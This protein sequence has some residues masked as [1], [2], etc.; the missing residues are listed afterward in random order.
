MGVYNST[1]NAGVPPD[2]KVRACP[3]GRVMEQIFQLI[4]QTC[5][6][7]KSRKGEYDRAASYAVKA[8]R[9]TLEGERDRLSTVSFRIKT[10]ESLKEKIIRRK[11]YR[12]AST[13]QGVLSLLSDALGVMIECRFVSDEAYLFGRLKESFSE[14]AGGGYFSCPAFPEL[15]LKL[16]EPQPQRQ[17]NGMDI[18]RVDGRVRLPE[19]DVGFELQ[20]KSLVNRFWSDIEHSVVY[21]N[22][23]LLPERSFPVRMLNEVRGNLLGIDSMLQ[24]IKEQIERLSE[25][26]GERL[27]MK[28]LLSRL[29][30]EMIN[31]RMTDLMGVFPRSHDVSRLLAAMLVYGIMER[32]DSFQQILALLSMRIEK[33]TENGSAEVGSEIRLDPAEYGNSELAVRVSGLI[34]ADFDWHLFFVYYRLLAAELDPHQD[35]LFHVLEDNLTREQKRSAEF[36]EV[37]E[38]IF[39]G[40]DFEREED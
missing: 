36:S 5:F 35:L 31:R 22:N 12:G 29:L 13:P 15:W 3:A 16:G 19:L 14:E 27:D 1:I 8:L 17:Q 10:A 24:L 38:T 11:Y 39:A 37:A 6:L 9:K 30:N 20:I 40:A 28:E 25:P 2:R 4:E 33:E 23:A 34:N 18:Y 32:K 26:V 21:K 7:H